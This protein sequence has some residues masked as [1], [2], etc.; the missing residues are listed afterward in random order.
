GEEETG[1]GHRFA[2]DVTL[3]L[4]FHSVLPSPDFDVWITARR[5]YPEGQEKWTGIYPDFEKLVLETAD[6]TPG[7]FAA[8]VAAKIES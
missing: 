6:R 3:R 1:G 4:L 2:F 7:E 8:A 5:N